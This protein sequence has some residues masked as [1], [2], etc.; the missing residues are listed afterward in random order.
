M[1]II[2]I[3]S[4]YFCHK[5]TLEYSHILYWEDTVRDRNLTFPCQIPPNESDDKLKECVN[6]LVISRLQQ[7]HCRSFHYFRVCAFQKHL[8]MFW[9]QQSYKK[10]FENSRCKIWCENVWRTGGN[11][12]CGVQIHSFVECTWK[13]VRSRE[14]MFSMFSNIWNTTSTC[15]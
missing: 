11:C 2:C 7:C 14:V 1:C 9:K 10:H 5:Q 4:I 12:H 8:F 13:C 6:K 15:I 3:Q